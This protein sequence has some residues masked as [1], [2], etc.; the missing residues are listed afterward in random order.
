MPDAAGQS[1]QH[2]QQDGRFTAIADVSDA[3]LARSVLADAA[4]NDTFPGLPRPREDVTIVI[5]R[6]ARHMRELSGPGIPEWGIA[7]A[8]P[9]LR[10]I[11]IQGRGA[12]SAAGDPL[13]AVRHEL[14]H[15]ALHEFLGDLP[16]RWFD[17][18]YA[19]YAAG[20]WRRDDA[21]A[22]QLALALRGVPT[23]A[24]IDSAFYGGATRAQYAYALAH[25]AVADLAALDSKRGLSLF[26]AEWRAR[27]SLDAAVRHSYGI[28]LGTYEAMWRRRTRRRYGALA[29]V[30]DLTLAIVILLAVIAPFYVA[31]R[32]RDQLR[33]AAMRERDA[34]ADERARASAIDELLGASGS[35]A[36]TP[37]PPPPSDDRTA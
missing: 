4:R 20:E 24:G 19:T 11:V 22:T 23:L 10:R 7:V 16:P 34:E 33:L 25:R 36:R 9:S 32:R 30:T 5:A 15:L 28:T 18:G 17:E 35:A 14:A 2:R 1:Q 27:G 13:I 31:R 6:D 21:L 12:T 29:V 8:V 26:F 37:P 3:L